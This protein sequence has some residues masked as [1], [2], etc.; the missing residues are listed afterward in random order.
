MADIPEVPQVPEVGAVPDIAQAPP[1]GRPLPLPQPPPK[2]PEKPPFRR[3]Q[4]R[5][6]RPGALVNFRYSFF[7]HDPTPLMLVAGIWQSGLVAGI[8]LHYLTFKY[9]SK[10]LKA[11]CNNPTFG[12]RL[13]KHDR[14]LYN[15]FRSYKPDGMKYK[16]LLDCD[17]VMNVLGS[18]RSWRPTVIEAIKQQVREQLQQ[19][20]NESAEE[21]MGMLTPPT[22]SEFTMPSDPK[23]TQRDKRLSFFRREYAPDDMRRG[24]QPF[25]E[26]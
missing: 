19:Q 17:Y 20:Y 15:S 8:N 23:I 11:Y 7:Q 6:I 9:I 18:M 24:V 3:I 4:Y 14:F 25:E 1:I 22:G 13:I 21:Y 10:I 26:E 16:R 2:P 5:T 12:Y